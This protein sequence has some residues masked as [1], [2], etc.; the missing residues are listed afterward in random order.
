MRVVIVADNASTRF[1]GEAFIPFNYFRLLLQRKVDVRLVVHARNRTE[2]SGCFPESLERLYFVE[3]TWLHKAL[4]RLGSFLPRRL[5]EATTGLLLHLVTEKAQHRLVRQ[6]VKTFP[7]DV[8]HQPIPVSPKVPSTIHGYGARVIIGPLNGGMDY[9][10]A[11]KRREGFLSAAILRIARAAADFINIVIPGKL[12]ADVVLV[13]NQRTHR[14]LP[15]GV[16]G[17]ILEMVDNAVDFKIWHRKTTR[18]TSDSFLKLIFVGRLIELKAVDLIIEAIK[19]LPPNVPVSLEIVG[20]GPMKGPWQ[21]RCRELG[22]ESVVRFSGFLPQQECADRLRQSDVFVMPSLHDCGGAVVLEAMATGLPVVATA[23]G[24]PLDY[25]DESCGILVEPSSRK[26]LVEGFS[27]AIIRLAESAT[28]REEMGEA[29][30]HRTRR[31]FDWERKIDHILEV[32]ASV[33]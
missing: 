22:L 10:P 8:V 5:S 2:L 24:G 18:A 9:P 33:R 20:D 13:A 27:N 1:G 11:F 17:T 7:V 21:D 16:R 32:Y 30:Y 31:D 15:P 25:L 19:T 28:L 23:W 26:A 29:G 6:L 12:R 3:D 14:A 4:F